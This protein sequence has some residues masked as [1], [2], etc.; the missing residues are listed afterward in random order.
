[1]SQVAELRP[2][3]LGYLLG[4]VDQRLLGVAD[5]GRP[6]VRIV[7]RRLAHLDHIGHGA[8]L[9]VQNQHVPHTQVAI[10]GAGPAGLMLGALLGRAR[11][12]MGPHALRSRYR[13]EIHYGPV[14]ELAG[15]SMAVD[16]QQEVVKDLI[17]L[18]LSTGATLQVEVAD[19]A[20]R[21]IESARPR[22][23]YTLGGEP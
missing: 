16:G 14:T 19:V 4:Q 7:E 1:R 12:A 20:V 23:T 10:V 11:G 5:R 22:V 8:Q 6:V 18:R 15:R 21:D 13:G 2:G 9:Y 3:R 17:G